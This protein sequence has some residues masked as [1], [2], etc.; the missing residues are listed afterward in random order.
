MGNVS[1]SLLALQEQLRRAHT[2]T[3]A[4]SQSEL[5]VH[6][7]LENTSGVWMFLTTAYVLSRQPSA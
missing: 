7:L 2:L 1:L 3:P 5:H 6:R 4:V